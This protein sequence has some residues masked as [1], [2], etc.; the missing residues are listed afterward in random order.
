MWIVAVWLILACFGC[1]SHG[2]TSSI[3]QQGR[4][5]LSITSAPADATC[6]Q[7]L[8]AGATNVERDVDVTPGQSTVLLLEGLPE[9]TDTI[10]VNAF[11]G[12]CS[13][14]TPA[15]VPTWVGDPVVVQVTR[16]ATD[17][18]VT[19]HRNTKNGRVN[20]G[21]NFDDDAGSHADGSGAAGGAG[22]GAGGTAGGGGAGGSAGDTVGAGG[23]ADDAG[24]TGG[25]GG[26]AGDTVGTGGSAGDNTDGGSAGSGGTGG[27]GGGDLCVPLQ[28]HPATCAACEDSFCPHDPT[29]CPDACVG[30]PACSDYSTADAP[31]CEAVLGC[32]R[33]SN[34]VAIGVTSCYCGTANVADCLGGLGNGACRA[35]IEAGLKMTAPNAILL[36]LTNVRLPAGGALSIGQC[37]H[38]NC[39]SPDNGGS[40]EC[41]PY[42]N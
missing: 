23:S 4:I 36:S 28:S 3:E 37:D 11:A 38:D 33:V 2:S 8:V 42:C 7:V 25:T 21:V 9:G 35:Q 10:T 30:Q 39:G 41:V 40:N 18:T 16:D 12:S 1:S 13:T 29:G 15:S 26:S 34:C 19:L 24:S 17:V 32:I 31:L 27:S 22:A 20:L 14:L 5:S 6:I